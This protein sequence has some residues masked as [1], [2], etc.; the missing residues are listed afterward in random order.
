M[1]KHLHNV[2]ECPLTQMRNQ[3]S[4]FQINTYCFKKK[5]NGKQCFLLYPLAVLSILFGLVLFFYFFCLTT[6]SACFLYTYLCIF[7]LLVENKFYIICFKLCHLLFFAM[8]IENKFYICSTFASL[9]CFSNFKILS[10]LWL[11][12][13]TRHGA[14][15]G[16]WWGLKCLFSPLL[17]SSDLISHF[18]CRKHAVKASRVA[19]H[20][21]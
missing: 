20:T 17:Q 19:A 6:G 10:T 21:T 4:C 5:L 14:Q 3:G 16:C 1:T 9:F 7:L 13:N 8:D 15:S 11:V 12:F 18:K 2:V